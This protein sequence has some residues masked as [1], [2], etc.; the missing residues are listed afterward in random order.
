MGITGCLNLLYPM[1]PIEAVKTRYAP[2][3][4]KTI[5]CAPFTHR[6]EKTPIAASVQYAKS[7]MNK[8][9]FRIHLSLA[10][11]GEVGSTLIMSSRS[12]APVSRKVVIVFSNASVKN[13]RRFSITSLIAFLASVSMY[14]VLCPGPLFG[15][16]RK[17]GFR[18]AVSHFH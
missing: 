10:P 7:T 11:S 15:V 9:T 17:I 6:L 3:T 1:P 4:I 14:L 2:T 12:V 8:G 16:E 5:S 13:V 18:H